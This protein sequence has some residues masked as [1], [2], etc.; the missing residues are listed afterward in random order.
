[1]KRLV[2]TCFFL[3]FLS[4]VQA[5]DAKRAPE[6]TPN[7]LL[8]ISGAAINT[9]VQRSVDQTDPVEEYIQDTPVRGLARTLGSVHAELVANPNQAMIDVVLRGQV[10]GRTV[11]IRP[12]VYVHASSVTS[13]D[14]RRRVVVDRNGIRTFA[15]PMF[16]DTT[17]HLHDVVSKNEPDY[18]AMSFARQGAIRSLPMAEG[19]TAYKTAKKAA[20]GL[21]QELAP[22]LISVSQSVGLALRGA[23]KDGVKLET[24]DLNTT[25]TALQ[26]RV[27][28]ATAERSPAGAVPDLPADI[29]LGLRVHQSLVN[30]ASQKKLAGHTFL[31]T[32]I[33]KL[34]DET[35]QGLLLDGRKDPSLKDVLKTIE[36]L[37]ADIGAKNATITLT[38]K[39]P[40]TVAF[41]D[42][43]FLVQMNVASIQMNNKTYEGVRVTAAYRIENS[44]QGV[45]VVRQG[46]V[47]FLPPDEPTPPAEKLEPQPPTFL[48]V[49]EILFAEVLK[50]RLI[51]TI[52][53]SDALPNVHFLP[54][55]AGA[56][57]GWL[58]I[59]WTVAKNEPRTN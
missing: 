40:M 5:G 9:A 58:G 32:E 41:R 4:G 18:R 23:A 38:H 51:V 34:Y 43:G 59:G 57:D 19:E 20:D 53:L 39:D 3:T 24:F 15:G 1:M 50:E 54:P 10:F 49:R 21:A 55:R 12:F 17:I 33:S 8:D 22:P 52:P 14:V 7:L 44:R 56:R 31:I 6:K 26:A 30:E 27:R 16:A 42:Q 46:L 2:L 11:G 47:K 35:S 13:L 28:F 37:L 45:H 36:K 25:S 29:D 48:I